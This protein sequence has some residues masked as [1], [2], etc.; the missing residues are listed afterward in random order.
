MIS[1]AY[2]CMATS[3]SSLIFWFLVRATIP[4]KKLGFTRIFTGLSWCASL[5]IARVFQMTASF[6]KASVATLRRISSLET[7]ALSDNTQKNLPIASYS[8]TPALS[9]T[10]IFVYLFRP[11]NYF[12]LSRFLAIFLFLLPTV[13]RVQCRLQIL[14]YLPC[15]PAFIPPLQLSRLALTHFPNVSNSA[16][17]ACIPV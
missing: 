14:G 13:H 5:L 3:V 11:S 15:L 8:G 4:Y 16:V 7:S 1:L 12:F 6:D 10:I 9:M 17:T 2:S